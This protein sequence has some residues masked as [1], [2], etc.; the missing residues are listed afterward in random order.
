M[1]GKPILRKPVLSYAIERQNNVREKEMK[2]NAK[3]LE[4]E[5]DNHEAYRAKRFI[6]THADP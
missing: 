5:R 2:R 4:K 6:Y 1:S 3:N